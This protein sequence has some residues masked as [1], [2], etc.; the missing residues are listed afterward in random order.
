MWA[1]AANAFSYKPPAA[2]W[3]FKR[4]EKMGFKKP[5]DVRGQ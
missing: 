1:Q 5:A 3:L 4:V 2:N